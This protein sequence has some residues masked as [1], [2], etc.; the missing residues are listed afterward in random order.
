MKQPDY[1][2]QIE[3]LLKDRCTD[4]LICCADV[5]KIYTK[6]NS[7]ISAIGFATLIEDEVRELWSAKRGGRSE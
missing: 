5:D 2:K 1:L 6:Y 3:S 4:Y 7:K